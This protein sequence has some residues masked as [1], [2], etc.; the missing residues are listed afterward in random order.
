L[1]GRAVLLTFSDD[2]GRASIR[3]FRRFGHEALIRAFYGI[4]RRGQAPLVDGA[5]GRLVVAMLEEITAALTAAPG[6]G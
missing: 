4:L 3:N 2:L 5:Q 1:C 6:R